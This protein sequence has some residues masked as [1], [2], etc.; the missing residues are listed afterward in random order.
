M[1]VNHVHHHMTDQ[2]ITFLNDFE[3]TMHVYCP[4][5]IQAKTIYKLF[6]QIIKFL[7]S[8]RKSYLNN[9]ICIVLY[10]RNT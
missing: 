2:Y 8:Y 6:N 7:N 10:K 3:D 4:F 9:S 5:E 1:C